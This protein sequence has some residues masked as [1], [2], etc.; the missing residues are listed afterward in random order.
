MRNS[1][2]PGS[3][4]CLF[5]CL[6]LPIAN[7]QSGSGGKPT[8]QELFEQRIMPIFRS[9]KPSS[10]VQCHLSS[11]DLKNYILPS[12]EKT[13]ASLR[14]QGLIDLDDPDQSKILK[15][16]GMGEKDLDKGAR[17]IHEKT[18]QAEYEAFANWI[19]ACA[20]DPKMRDLPKLSAEDRARPESAD[21]VIRHARKS[22]L[23]D[24]FVRNIWTQ[25]M[26]CF[27]CHTPYEID[28]NNPKQQAAIKTRHQLEEKF[29]KDFMP[30]LNI[31]R[32]TPEET[33]S[34]LIERSRHPDEGDLPLLNLDDPRKSLLLLKPLSKLPMKQENG[35]FEPPSSREPVTHMGGLKMHPDDQSY[36]S[37][38]A[39][40]QDYANVVQGKYVSVED[41]PADNWM[42]TQKVIKL[43]NAPEDWNVGV[44]VQLFLH[45]WRDKDRSWSPE[46]IAFTQGTVT[47]RRL[48]NGA[49]FRITS[50]GE[51]AE[52]SENNDPLGGGTYLVRVYVDSRGRLEKDPTLLL[53][54]ED[55]VGETELKK[56][57][58][59]D[60]FQQAPTV[61]A[62]K[63][64]IP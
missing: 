62:E 56:S 55:F 37:F 9:P 29:G 58:W 52:I 49:L 36:K 10:C 28:P 30:R 13:F 7:A 42:G 24:S 14:D 5:V 27:P 40:I 53:G 23:V 21:E 60:G 33:L 57:R 45:A 41:L 6:S 47:P 19:E 50:K 15:L 20:K 34:N 38:V 1:F 44:P 11:V 22:R 16:I 35:E 51:P 61:S 59:R 43:S 17:L 64:L 3:I 2:F 18:R 54:T 12:Q 31:F 25:R 32:E 26:R 8:P 48:V 46:P 39:W 63:L 4:V